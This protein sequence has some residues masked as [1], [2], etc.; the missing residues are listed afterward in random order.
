MLTYRIIRNR[1]VN[2]YILSELKNVDYILHI[3]GE[4]AFLNTAVLVERI[5]N[6][7]AIRMCVTVELNKLKEKDRLHLW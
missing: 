7:D 2:G 5:N 3:Q 4:I 1:A 6:L